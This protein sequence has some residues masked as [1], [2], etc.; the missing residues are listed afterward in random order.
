MSA[1]R[2]FCKLVNQVIEL[3]RQFYDMPRQFRI[4]GELGDEQ[5]LSFDNSMM[6][7]Q[8]QGMDFGMDMGYRLPTFD[9]K[10]SAQSKTAYSKNSQ[11]EL[12]LALYTQGVFNPQMCDQALMLL[13]MMDF[14]GKDELMQKI[15][16]NGTL[17]QQ[18][19][20]YQQIALQLAAQTDPALAE[21]L[22]QGIMGGAQAQGSPGG[23]AQPFQGNDGGAGGNMTKLG[24][25]RAQAQQASQPSA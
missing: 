24:N 20:M 17:L 18:M 22:A 3:I 13:D 2:A 16:Q 7:P 1:Y 5:F 4:T 14:E 21:Q 8:A 10:V 6:Q 15:A 23:G 19:A 12:A 25:A 11:N 9:V